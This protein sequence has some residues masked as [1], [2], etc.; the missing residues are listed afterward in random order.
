LALL[1]FSNLTFGYGETIIIDGAGGALHPGNVIGLVGVNGG[2]KTTLLR[3]LTGQLA[4]SSGRLQ[5]QKNLKL[6]LVGQ[7]VEGD[8]DARV[9]QYVRAGRDDLLALERRIADL[10]EL[11]AAEGGQATHDG[12]AHEAAV[13]RLGEAQAQYASLGGHRWD[14][15]V[16][17]LLLGLSFARAEFEQ[18][19]GSLSG[20]QRQKAALARSLLS[21]SQCLIFDEPTNH[22]DLEAQAFFADYV[23]ALASSRSDDSAMAGGQRGVLL[24]SHDRWLLD[25]LCTHIWELEDGQLFRY[26]GNYSSYAP[27]RDQRRKL[28]TEAYLKQQEQIA[29]TEE[30]IR[31]NIAGQ[32]TKQA[33]GRRTH[34]ARME[35]LEKPGSD[36]QMAFVLKPAVP[37]GEQVLVVEDLEFTYRNTGSAALRGGDLARQPQDGADQTEFDVPRVGTRGNDAATEDGA[38]V[39]THVRAGT[40]GLDLNPPL[41]YQRAIAPPPDKKLLDGLTFTLLRQERLAIVGPNGSGKTTLLK[42]LTRQ[43]VPDRGLT[44]WGSNVELGLFS[45]DSADLRAGRNL[46]AEIRE[47]EPNLSDGEARGYLA[48][49]GFSGDD[50]MK[51]VGQLSGGERSRLSLAK[52][53][54]R[55]PNVLVLD[56]PTN[57]LDIYAREALEGFLSAYEG[58]ILMVTHDRALLERLCQRLVVFERASAEAQAAGQRFEVSFFRGGYDQYVA[59]RELQAAEHDGRAGTPAGPREADKS[60]GPTVPGEARLA[61]TGDE[62]TGIPGLTWAELEELAR[63]QRSSVEGYARKQAEREDRRAGEIETRIE[64]LEARSAELQRAQR[65]AD[66]AGR[67]ADLTRLQAELDELEQE[68]EQ[69]FDELHSVQERG[70]AWRDLADGRVVV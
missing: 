29:R 35:R 41:H 16:E 34:L 2:G 17:R 26:T 44:A 51:D 32:N 47:V 23:K 57:H 49:F 33:R 68:L 64:A 65:E 54:R 18:T 42:L 11:L 52:I 70:D 24:V 55:R 38:T 63:R 13:A 56:E 39:P 10:T 66:A 45:Q 28:A 46:L 60:V 12:T 59:W 7:K 14:S 61:P 58:T 48:R 4:P 9:F 37:T 67:Y 36:P 30:Y 8:E 3:L 50:V 25:R 15:E 69:A 1:E 31:R 21:G 53:F 5:R 40:F 19:L 62:S 43:L 20:G 27:Q 22:L 6:A